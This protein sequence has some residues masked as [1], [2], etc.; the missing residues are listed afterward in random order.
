MS[1]SIQELVSDGTLSTVV[2][3]IEY[4]QRND[5]YMRI[6]GVE[7]PQSGAPS[8]YTW[9][10]I[11]NSTIRVLPVV[12]SGITVVIYRRTDLDAMYN[13]YSQNAQ[14][15]EHTI[16]ENNQQLLF[17]AQEYFE[18][19]VTAKGIVSIEYISEDETN[20][21]YRFVLADGTYTNSFAIPKPASSG[22]GASAKEALRRSYADA[23]L[24]VKGCTEDGATL[25][26]TTDVII[27][28]AN[29]KG[30]SWA[31]VY[32]AGGYIV[33]PETDPTLN[34]NFVDRSGYLFLQSN[35][36]HNVAYMPASNGY[37]LKNTVYATDKP[38]LAPTDG[39]DATD[40]IN[41]ALAFCAV[42][43]KDLV[44]DRMFKISGPVTI[45][46][47]VTVICLTR[48]CGLDSTATGASKA[49]VMNGIKSRFIGGTIKGINNPT[50]ATIRQDGVSMTGTSSL[51]E[52]RDVLVTGFFAKGLAGTGSGIAVAD[53]GTMN[54]VT[55]CSITDSKFLVSLRGSGG[56]IS[57]NYISNHYLTQ[58]AETKPWTSASNFWDGIVSEGIS[59]Y[60]ITY[61]TVT[62][63][64]QSGIYT[65]GNG[66]LSFSNRIIGNTVTR[67]WNRGIDQGVN[68]A[69]SVS[70]DV[71]GQLITSNICI[72]NRENNIWL[73]G[74]SRCNVNGNTSE[75][76]SD[77]ATIF[78]GYYGGHTGV[79]LTNG[80]AGAIPFGNSITSNNCYDSEGYNN[81]SVSCGL[82]ATG[83]TIDG[84]TAPQG[85][86]IVNNSLLAT[87]SFNTL[88]VADWTPQLIGGT[89]TITLGTST[90]RTT[91]RNRKAN[92]TCVITVTS[93]SSPSGHLTI[94]YV[95]PF[96]GVSF[97]YSD[98]RVSSFDGL[99]AS[100]GSSQLI[101]VMGGTSDQIS[102]SRYSNGVKSFDLR[103]YIKAG[104]TLTITGEVEF[105]A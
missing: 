35:L 7:T 81:I 15:D 100:I 65:G 37:R 85:V 6:D 32:P 59:G 103:G 56:E 83:N 48:Q 105:Y 82:T 53:S 44:L 3:G 75:Y 69:L 2:L 63:C 55:L 45:P 71:I 101:A 16:D 97:R 12:P 29:G 40:P 22:D 87:N 49:V 1:L 31:G 42:N 17:I 99:D 26:S 92:F 78:A 11:D 68:A 86:Y 67:N 73:A 93:V 39:S 102:V 90:G 36:N 52:L 88:R 19:A 27:H 43:N 76:N 8:G 10:F 46:S 70:N 50:S 60:L 62:E 77:Y 58:T 96:S 4:L 95:A 30:Y 23:G 41:A 57:N 21:Y 72:N 74:V 98:V 54:K 14:F 104:S 5:I 33:T 9:N 84:N 34:V 24:T 64:G 66:G 80:A 51:C 94:G 38:F 79:A 47:N 20:A 18:Q 89:G 25:T 28:N 13:I 91:I 61:N